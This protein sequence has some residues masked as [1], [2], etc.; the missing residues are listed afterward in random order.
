MRLWL[1]LLAA[2]L[3]AT[4]AAFADTR[5]PAGYVVA[6]ETPDGAPAP[7]LRRQGQ[8]LDVLVWTPLFDGD[9]LE[10]SGKASVAIETAKDKR[11]VVDAARSP[12]RVSGELGGGSK[13]AGLASRLG[14]LFKAKPDATPTNLVGRSDGALRK[15]ARHPIQEPIRRQRPISGSA[16]SANRECTLGRRAPCHA[17]H[18][19]ARNQPGAPVS[20][21]L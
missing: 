19:A 6:V 2:W 15:A 8:E 17:T 7:I 16:R 4:S 9:A 18:P 1:A 3:L 20:Q 21:D 5:R 11:L 13:F 14:E 12:H 10:V